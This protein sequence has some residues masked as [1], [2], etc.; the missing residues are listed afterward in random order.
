MS[1]RLGAAFGQ[2]LACF[3]RTW[4]ELGWAARKWTS[5]LR[6]GRTSVRPAWLDDAA[7]A[8]LLLGLLGFRLADCLYITY[9]DTDANIPSIHRYIS[10]WIHVYMDPW[11]H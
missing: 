2:N 9:I 8:M 11:T 1:G 7:I 5:R 6:F 3:D 10:A 4:V